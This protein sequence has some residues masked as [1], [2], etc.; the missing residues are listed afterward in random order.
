MELKRRLL[1]SPILEFYFI[2]D[3]NQLQKQDDLKLMSTRPKASI[4]KGIF[5]VLFLRC[6]WKSNAFILNW[7]YLSLVIVTKWVGL[8]PSFGPVV[9]TQ[10]KPG[11]FGACALYLLTY[12]PACSH[13]IGSGK[14]RAELSH[15]VPSI[16]RGHN[17]PCLENWG[18]F[19]P[20]FTILHFFINPNMHGERLIMIF[21]LTMA[22]MADMLNPW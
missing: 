10:P 17:K 2:R 7:M 6:R 1:S 15:D 11:T 5:V 9:R 8:D 20:C 3:Q 4:S 18:H 19:L 14:Q 16:N 22:T 21:L 13:S 12:R